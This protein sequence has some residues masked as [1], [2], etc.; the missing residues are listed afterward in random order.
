MRGAARLLAEALTTVRAIAPAAQVVVR[1][2]SKYY[3]ADVVAAAARYN[4][5]VSLTT[6][7]NPSIHAA[8]TQ[9]PGDAWRPIHYPNAFA[10]TGT[11]ERVR[12]ALDP[13]LVRHRRPQQRHRSGAAPPLAAARTTHRT[14]APGSHPA[15]DQRPAR[16]ARLVSTSR[17]YTTPVCAP[18]PP[19]WSRTPPSSAGRGPQPGSR[20]GARLEQRP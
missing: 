20:A 6:G 3:T 2:D 12:G 16:T 17:S 5:S 1:G 18:A 8:I 7:A 19:W 14:G 10:D 11:G 13:G 15:A 9:I 4:A